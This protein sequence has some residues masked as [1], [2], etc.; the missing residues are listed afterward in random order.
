MKIIRGKKD[1][2]DSKYE[3]VYVSKQEALELIVSLSSQLAHEDANYRR[4]E[5]HTNHGLFSIAVFEEESHA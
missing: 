3:M 1:E 5:T 2:P 4:L